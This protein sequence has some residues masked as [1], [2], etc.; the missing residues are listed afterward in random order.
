MEDKAAMTKN[1]TIELS[2]G[3]EDEMI[4][5]VPIEDPSAIYGDQF[6][7]CG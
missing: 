4:K 1:E 7:T 3:K 6:V 5:V 2:R